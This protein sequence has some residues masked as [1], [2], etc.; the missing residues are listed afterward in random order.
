MISRYFRA[1]ELVG[2]LWGVMIEREARGAGRSN[3]Y[4][5]AI[6]TPVVYPLAGTECWA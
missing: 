5:S 4:I 1:H 3:V 6:T 2:Y